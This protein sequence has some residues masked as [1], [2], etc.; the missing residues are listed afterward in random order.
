MRRMLR[1]VVL[2]ATLIGVL[3]LARPAD[4]QLL[5]PAQA[6]PIPEAAPAPDLVPDPAPEPDRQMPLP[7]WQRTLYKTITFQAVVN[8]TDV[9]MFDLV[10]GAHPVVLGGFFVTNAATAA[11]LYYGF[12]YLWRAYGPP[13]EET[14]EKTI[15]KKAVLFQ[16]TNSGRIFA[17]GWILGATPAQATMLAGALFVTDTVVFYGNEYIWDIMRPTKGAP[18][19]PIQVPDGLE[20]LQI[21]IAGR[22][23]AFTASSVQVSA[24]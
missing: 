8:A 11:G 17:L 5:S 9:L 19:S 6:A 14:D 7:S 10:I 4:A 20:P 22:P 16:A 18:P 24:R 21:P 13:L 12:E 2:I 15:A 1:S 23:G 3:A